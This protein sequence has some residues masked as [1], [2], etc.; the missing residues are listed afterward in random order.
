MMKNALVAM[1]FL[2]LSYPVSEACVGKVLH[3]GAV[4]SAEG[5][6]LAEIVSALI[7]ERT[8]TS[9]KVKLFGNS[10][11]L[12]NAVKVREIEI[13]VEN[14]SQALRVMNRPAE[15]D[16]ARAYDEAKAAYAQ[17]RGLVW[18]KPFGFLHGSGSQGAA[19]TATVLRD[20]VLNNF[21]ALPRVLNKLG[22][23]INDA[24]YMKLMRSVESGEPAKDVAR[25]FLKS[26]KLL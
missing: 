3:I 16:A 26:R 6:V 4:N 20:D 21:P 13:M 9:V 19:H 8:G 24:A 12:Y 1:M 23:A 25:D 15:A 22:N 10:Q 14:T 7:N 11:E 17:E 5:R 2:F 18:L